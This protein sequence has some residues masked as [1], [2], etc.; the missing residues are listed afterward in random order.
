MSANRGMLVEPRRLRSSGGCTQMEEPAPAP[1]IT[2]ADA[3]AR[4]VNRTAI[5]LFRTTMV[6]LVAEIESALDLALAMHHARTPESAE[7]L[8]TEVFWRFPL[9][10]RVDQLRR[11]LENTGLDDAYPFVVP[12]VEKAIRVRHLLAH[13][14]AQSVP[15]GIEVYTRRRG[16]RR[17]EILDGNYLAWLLPEA[18]RAVS[19]LELITAR[20]GDMEVWGALYGFDD[21]AP[22]RADESTPL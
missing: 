19:D 3:A 12:V 1:R 14:P 4:V 10:V 11:A 9:D 20:I 21:S 6:E 18:R 5:S 17:A 8:V 15:K 22:S 16:Q 2:W 7:I 13:S